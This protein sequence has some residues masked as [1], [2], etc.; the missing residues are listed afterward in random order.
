MFVF[1]VLLKPVMI[2]KPILK[3]DNALSDEVVR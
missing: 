3:D 2:S 1:T